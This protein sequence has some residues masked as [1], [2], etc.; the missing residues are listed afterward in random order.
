MKPRRDY[1]EYTK[2]INDT[3]TSEK[4]DILMGTVYHMNKT[5]MRFSP[6]KRHPIDTVRSQSEKDL[7]LVNRV[8]RF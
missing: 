5:P 6:F 7:S 4:E 3:Y 1:D 8:S 2:F